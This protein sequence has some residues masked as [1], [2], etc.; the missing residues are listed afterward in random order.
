MNTATTTDAKAVVQG[1]LDA[2]VAGD[3]EAIRES[4]AEDATWTI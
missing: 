2:L 1:Y 4:F 3:L